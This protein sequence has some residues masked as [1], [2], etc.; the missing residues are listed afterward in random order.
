[1]SSSSRIWSNFS[2]HYIVIGYG[3]PGQ[4]V[5]K[6][7]L[8]TG[9][10]VCVIE[11]RGELIEAPEKLGTASV[12][13]GDGADDTCLREARIG[14]AAGA[15]V[16]AAPFAEAIFI[17]LSARQ[18]NQRIPVLNRVESGQGPACWCDSGS[19]HIMGGWRIAH[20]LT[21][22]HTTNFLDLA[23]LAEHEDLLMDEAEIQADCRWR[24]RQLAQVAIA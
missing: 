5:V 10:S 4:L 6:E 11:R 13:N 1:M 7:L 19:P 14:Y 12:V 17:T 22:P 9:H 18:L 23:R 24:D 16:T 3:R 2:G 15:A 20:G 21:R 8:D